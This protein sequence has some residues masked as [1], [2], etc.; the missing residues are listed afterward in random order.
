MSNSCPAL[1]LVHVQVC[2][3]DG[4]FQLMDLECVSGHTTSGSTAV[5][6]VALGP[7]LRSLHNYLYL[8]LVLFRLILALNFHGPRY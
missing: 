6:D 5:F 3:D 2:V 4:I 7:R 8:N 1:V